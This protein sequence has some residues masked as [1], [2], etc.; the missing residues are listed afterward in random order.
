MDRT[1]FQEDSEPNKIEDADF[2][3]LMLAEPEEG[4]VVA[5]TS[6]DADGEAALLLRNGMLLVNGE[7]AGWDCV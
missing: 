4:N 2:V 6:S 1:G 3:I 7:V 5:D